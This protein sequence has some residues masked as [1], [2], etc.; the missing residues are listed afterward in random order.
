MR[1]D[2]KL[3][4]GRLQEYGRARYPFG[5]ADDLSY[6]LKM[7]TDRGERT[8]LGK[9]FLERAIPAPSATGPRLGDLIGVRLISLGA[10]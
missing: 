5:R 8:P 2:G 1:R 10:R 3:I 6:Y 4:V 9:G 7:L